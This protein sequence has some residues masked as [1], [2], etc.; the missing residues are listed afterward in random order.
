MS[1]VRLLQADDHAVVRAGIRNALKG[2][3][4]VEIVGEVG[5]GSGLLAALV[6]ME[7]D[8]LLLDVTM[9][10]FEPILTIRQIRAR[11]P[12]IKILVVSAYDDDVYVQGL[13]SAGVDGYHL[14]DQPLKDL[15]LAVAALRRRCVALY[16]SCSSIL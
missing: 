16:G 12:G 7:P 1:K 5:D 3:T 2:L 10:E 8:C 11:Y 14:K 9:P 15:R 13:L 4:D 6:E